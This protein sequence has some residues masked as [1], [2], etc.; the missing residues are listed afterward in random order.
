MINQVLDTYE[1]TF[2]HKQRFWGMVPSY[3]KEFSL[4]QELVLI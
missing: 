4:G 2:S 3:L 1:G